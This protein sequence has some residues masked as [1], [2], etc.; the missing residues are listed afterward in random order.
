MPPSERPGAR[1]HE[2][3]RPGHPVAQLRLLR[4]ADEEVLV[5]ESEWVAAQQPLTT[6]AIGQTQL[7][8][9]QP[10]A[11]GGRGPEGASMR[12][13]DTP[14]TVGR[15]LRLT[16][17]PSFTAVQSAALGG[18]LAVWQFP[19]RPREVAGVAVRVALE[20]VLVLGLGLP[21]GDGLADLGHHLAGPQA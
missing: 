17:R 13:G 4:R 3:L 2:R 6:Q 16:R 10:L 9:A 1:A 19:A 14:D 8:S 15:A 5:E 11:P 12:I 18:G 7:G 21:E 20:V